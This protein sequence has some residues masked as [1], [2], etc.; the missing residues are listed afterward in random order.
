MINLE[1]TTIITYIDSKKDIDWVHKII[2]LREA[3]NNTN[4]KLLKIYI[5]TTTKDEKKKI[6][7]YCKENLKNIKYEIIKEGD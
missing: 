4:I 2:K 6:E 5:T 7:K 1:D 3:Y